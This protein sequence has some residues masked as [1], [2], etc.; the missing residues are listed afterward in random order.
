MLSSIVLGLRVLGARIRFDRSCRWS[1]AQL[2]A[3]QARRLEELRSF[4]YERSPFYRRFHRGLENRPLNEL[5]ILTKAE[6]MENFD[7]LVTDRAIRLADID[8]WMR[9]APGGRL[10][11]GKYVVLS[12]SGST[13]RRGIFLFDNRE[14]IS[15]LANISRP[16]RWAGAVKPGKPP[17]TATIASRTPWHYS[18]RISTAISPRLWPM[19][20]LD[21]GEPIPNLVRSLNEW[22]P[23]ILAAYPSV[24]R[25][26]VD[27]Q[28]SG[29]LQIHPAA[30]ATAAEVLTDETRERAREAWGVRVCDTYG[31]TEYS[32]IA[33]E[34]AHG[35]KHLLEDG[36]IIELVDER[37]RPVAPGERSDRVLLT[38]FGRRTQPLIRYEL[39]DVLRAETGDCECGR[40][41]RLIGSIEGRIEDVLAFPRR[42]AAAETVRLHPNL[43]HEI[44]ENLPASGWQVIQ[45]GGNITV[46]LTGLKDAAICEPLA[47]R[48]AAMFVAQDADV[49]SVI[50]RR[51]DTM[52][53]GAT[54]KAPLIMARAAGR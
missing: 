1:R 50:V 48:I 52:E 37:G 6:L 41:F 53:R 23:D 10:F 38:V 26:L 19:L 31:A 34:C 32:P 22:Q 21:A 9:N 33:A 16:M 7:E 51:V 27:E 43:F 36:A 13:G 42:G 24:L 44:L 14:W 47:G 4:A 20:L 3:H 11:H 8:Q 29:R 28:M 49:K 46:N 5:P 15:V 18:A 39:S 12:T 17:R 45:E 40:K 54:G 35:K 30:I 2:D 25:Q